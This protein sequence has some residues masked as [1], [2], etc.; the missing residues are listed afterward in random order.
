MNRIWF[1]P[2]RRWGL[3]LSV[4][5]IFLAAGVAVD[6]AWPARFTAEVRL[7]VAAGTDGSGRAARDQAEL[8]RDPGLIRRVLPAPLARGGTVEGVGAQVVRRFGGALGRRL[9]GA[10]A[11]ESDGV[12]ALRLQRGL[13]VAVAGDTDVV[14][15]RF[16]WGE[17]RFAADALNLI[18]AGYQ[19][20]G[21]DGAEALEALGRA[22]ARLETAQAE[23][24]A[25]DTQAA[26]AGPAVDPEA[27]RAE[28]G[29]IEAR[30]AGARQTADTVRLDRALAQQ[31]L[32]SVEGSYRS[33]AW[34]D[35]GDASRA[36]SAGFTS[37]L[38]KRQQLQ[39]REDSAEVRA[40]DRE[41]ARARE[42]NYATTRQIA[43]DAVSG[44]DDR[45]GKLEAGI[46]EDEAGLRG[47]DQHVSEME[48]LRQARLSKAAAVAEAQKGVAAAHARADAGWQA[49]GGARVV[50]E[51]V[52]PVEADFPGPAVVLWA[53][54]FVG[55]VA[56]VAAAAW[57]EARR[58]VVERAG[59]MSRLL[60]IEVL[61]R[62]AE[63][64]MPRLG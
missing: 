60:G 25:V 23:M 56:G 13:R 11:V 10:P 45:L 2:A 59:D 9:A 21:A 36:L 54:G 3:I 1:L 16:G 43:A 22:Q 15:A 46:R 62:L 49:L 29:R 20:T 63:M 64:P 47:L 41:I 4:V 18:V 35:G 28:R 7:A 34:V 57:A 12:F 38:V 40:L 24:A 58:R 51:A 55:V 31:K 19:R 44:L 17:A 6:A 5:A 8:L 61:A 32:E 37:L 30:L 50:S 14:V 53:A 39:G 42:Q 26:A 52:V 27:V 33:G 48:V